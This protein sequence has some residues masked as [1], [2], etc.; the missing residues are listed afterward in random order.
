MWCFEKL[1]YL[2]GKVDCCRDRALRPMRLVGTCA[3]RG[4]N[5][6][7]GYIVGRFI[8]Q[9][10][11]MGLFARNIV[12]WSMSPRVTENLVFDALMTAYWRRKPSNKIML[13]SDQGSQ[14]T[15]NG[16]KIY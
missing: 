6:P 2:E 11:V 1:N 10:V 3:Q 16:L 12:G 4:Y 5:T 7:R 13:H 15:S 14:Y 9:A 8:L